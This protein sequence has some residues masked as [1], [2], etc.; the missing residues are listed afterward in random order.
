[1]KKRPSSKRQQHK[2]N[3]NEK[4]NYY[5]VLEVRPTSNQDDIL[6]SYIRLSLKY[7]S[8]QPDASREQFLKIG[9]A[10]EVVSDPKRRSAYD[11]YL[12]SGGTGDRSGFDPPP[13]DTAAN[14]EE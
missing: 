4:N 11:R 1:M 8:N 5:N 10:Y 6:K 12:L 13:G 9:Q 7:K 3:K 2:K 14:E